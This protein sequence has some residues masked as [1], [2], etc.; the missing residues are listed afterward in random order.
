M[1]TNPF[2]FDDACPYGGEVHCIIYLLVGDR[3]KWLDE[4]SHMI[5]EL[6]TD[7][8]KT[9]T[10]FTA[11]PSLNPGIVAIMAVDGVADPRN[12]MYTK[13]VSHRLETILR[14]K[15]A[16]EHILDVESYVLL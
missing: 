6:N 14:D 1:S 11:I 3:L 9:A 8:H 5:V 7:H 12:P 15:F 4:N 16:G 2:S 10:Y 13:H